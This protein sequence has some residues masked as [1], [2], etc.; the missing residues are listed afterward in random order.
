MEFD[1]AE[2]ASA[3]DEFLTKMERVPSHIHPEIQNAME[4]ICR[5]LRIGKVQVCFYQTPADERAGRGDTA[6]LY[7]DKDADEERYIVKR[8]ITNDGNIVIYRIYQKS[9]DENWIAIERDKIDILIQMLFVFNS[10][11]R[12]MNLIDYLT[13][14]DR[15]FGTYNI[16]YF[17]KIA[18]MYIAQH[19][20]EDFGACHFNFKRLSAINQ[21]LGRERGTVL[22]IDFIKGLEAMLSSDEPV[23]RIGGDNFFVLFYKDNL[24]K[25]KEYLTGQELIYNTE[26]GDRISIS[27][28]AGFY[29]IPANVKEPSVIMDCVSTAIQL[30]KNVKKQQF[31]F[32]DEAVTLQMK[33]K[34]LVEAMFSHAIE[35]EEFAVYYQPKVGLRDYSL[36]G[37]EALCRWLHKGKLMP[38]DQF[39]PVLEQGTA[40]CTLDFYMLEHVC[41]DIR[42]W[43]DEGKKVVKV[44]VNLSRRH[45]GDPDLLQRLL[46]IIDKYHVPHQYIEIELT[47]TTT[48]A[49]F[50]DLKNIVFGLKKQGIS[51]SVDDFGV[52]YSS[53]NL[54]KDLPWSVIKIDK[55]FLEQHEGSR[56]NY[57]MLKYVISMAQEL[58]MEVIVEGVETVEHIKLLKENNCYLAQ[59][60]Y[61]DRP[62]PKDEFEKRLSLNDDC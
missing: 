27:A 51:T 60:F 13:F 41:Q 24:P 6:V 53:L 25:V 61:F 36:S 22:M 55:S 1:I 45:M 16:A 8:N 42:K 31:V 20:I 62:L 56:G 7:Y 30:A 49:D 35:N 10:R 33:N 54:I 21:L 59:G 5:L 57:V 47:E 58:G 28:A 39:I 40:I 3:M 17:I 2:Y 9:K 12:V 34:K 14:H 44:S 23:C 52:G 43:L 18:G 4:K 29:M 11:A 32:Y 46:S 19:R 26:T 50:N 48:D 15:D 38:P 37:A